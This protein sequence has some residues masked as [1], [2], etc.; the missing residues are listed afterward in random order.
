[1]AASRRSSWWLLASSCSDSGIS[2]RRGRV[3]SRDPRG[4]LSLSSQEGLTSHVNITFAPFHSVIYAIVIRTIWMKSKDHD[5]TVISNCSGKTN[6]CAAQLGEFRNSASAEVFHKP[7][8]SIRAPRHGMPLKGCPRQALPSPPGLP[9]HWE[10]EAGTLGHARQCRQSLCEQPLSQDPGWPQPL[11]PGREAPWRGLSEDTV[12]S[13]KRQG[14][15]F[16]WA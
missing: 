14:R 7:A 13:A 16:C 10:R 3:W 1:M 9:E 11:R 2:K 15:H 12:H 6:A 4:P 5:E 8:L